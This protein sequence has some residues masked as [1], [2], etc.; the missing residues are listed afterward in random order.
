MTTREEDEDPRNINILEVEGHREVEGPQID[1]PDITTSLKTKKVNIDIEAEPKFAQIGDY[2]DNAIVEKF[3]EL[4]CEY[5]DLFPKK[6]SDLKGIIG[7]LG[8]MKITLKL[9]V[10]PVKQRPYC[11]NPNTRN[12]FTRS[13]I[14]C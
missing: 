9:D 11:L 10:K 3:V 2:W 8:I 6:F 13:W 1:N 4:L 5:Q 7:D 12:M 14:R